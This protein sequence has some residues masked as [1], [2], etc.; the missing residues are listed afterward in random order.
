MNLAWVRGGEL[1]E[2][3]RGVGFTRTGE[4]NGVGAFDELGD[5]SEACEVIAGQFGRRED[6]DA[7]DRCPDSRQR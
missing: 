2:L 4:D 7:T 3:G 1:G 6:E 5:E